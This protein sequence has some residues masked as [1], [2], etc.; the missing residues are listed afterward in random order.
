GEGKLT[1]PHRGPGAHSGGA[2]GPEGPCG[3]RT[4][5]LTAPG[6]RGGRTPRVTPGCKGGHR[7]CS[8]GEGNPE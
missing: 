3:E 6:L 5:R 1:P 4:P 7:G 8:T 2:R